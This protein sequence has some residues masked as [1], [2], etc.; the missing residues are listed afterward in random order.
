MARPS[1]QLAGFAPGERQDALS[2][3]AL[4]NQVNVAIANA[5][6]RGPGIWIRG[7]IQGIA[8]HRSGHCYIDLVD[9]DAAPSR[10]RPVL[11]VN[12]WRTT[13]G[14][15]KAVL[16][17]QGVTLA[18]GMVLTLRGRVELYAPRSQVNFVAADIDVAA[19]LGRLA[20][21]R[22]ALL[23]ALEAEGLISR[24]K[25]LPVPHV[26]LRVGLVA[27]PRTEGFSD[28]LGQLE[29]SPFAFAVT[30]VPVQVQGRAAPLSI[31]R[32]LGVLDT[33]G[34]DVVVLVRGGGAKA[35]LVAFDAEP[36]ARA[37]AGHGLPVWTGIGHTGDQ[38]VADIVANRAFVTPTECGQAL[39]GQVRRWWDG[40]AA[41]GGAI[42]RRATDVLAA[43]DSHHAG[44]RLRVVNGARR[45]LDGHASRLHLRTGALATHAR[46]QLDTAAVAVARSTTRLAPGA[47]AV[48]DRQSER[49]TGWRR[50]LDAYD[51]DRQLER[52]YTLTVDQNGHIVRSVVAV[53]PRSRLTT[54]FADG[55]A[56]S[57]VDE[58]T[59]ATPRREDR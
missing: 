57:T 51:V 52:G 26:P 45:Q 58:V 36:V 50:L 3:S 32:A 10:D 13:W 18:V 33:D 40:V 22:A 43:G 30:V 5:F 12:C 44:V 38:S 2:I 29:A 4:L 28:F 7:E 1:N 53:G 9:P 34:C 41:A 35:D 59:R 6:P 14:P 8:E 31:A 25:A 27:S 23:A 15:L 20:A 54:R 48:L 19:L 55:T 37:V 46:R 56:T 42:G 21:Q 49:M 24:N 47:L 39:V 16:A 17:G 11:K